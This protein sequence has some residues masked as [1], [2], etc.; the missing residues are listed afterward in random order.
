MAVM[1]F[2]LGAA[3]S[4]A[5]APVSG[6]TLERALQLALERNERA[7][8]ATEQTQVAEARVARAR[9][10]FFPELT[11]SGQYTRRLREV[12]RTIGGTEVTLQS[13]NALSAVATLRMPLFD[14]R[15]FALHQQASELAQ[16]ARLEGDQ[17]RRQLAFETADAFFTTLGLERVMRAA[18][19]R[20]E[21]AGR[22]LGEAQARQRAQLVSSNDVTRA[23]L[24]ISTA[25][26]ELSVARGNS[27][28][29]YLNLG[30]LIGA[31]IAPPIQEPTALLE[32][33]DLPLEAGESLLQ[34]AL[35][36][37]LD[38][39]AGALR[40]EAARSAAREPLLRLIPS[41]GLGAHYRLTSDAGLAGHRDDGALTVELTWNLFDG[42]E[43]YAEAAER[44]AQARLAELEWEGRSRRV[45]AEVRAA[46]ARVTADQAALR[47][48]RLAVQI[49]Q[50]NAEETAVLYREGLA[51]SL[52]VADANVRRFD[53]DVALARAWYGLAQSYLELRAAR[54]LDALGS[55]P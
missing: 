11:A 36:R 33:A 5:E 31:E 19:R 1:A 25:E 52:E 35:E 27:E 28:A 22:S 39:R 7:A 48:A 50:R 3:P 23:Q 20:L 30:Y 32:L 51:G 18:Q 41:L 46:R 6:L 10:F 16:A 2:L 55:E 26:R 12:V 8:A 34:G 45:P 49:A 37:R 38:V 54:G 42:F 53:A 21:L 17:A 13:A 47:Q 15:G 40:H 4:L 43:R 24:E 29:A 9:S 44:R 14:A